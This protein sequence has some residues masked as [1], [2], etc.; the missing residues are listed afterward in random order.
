MNLP[1]DKF[2]MIVV[3]LSILGA[4]VGVATKLP[5][6]LIPLG[7]AAIGMA[8]FF[9]LLRRKRKRVQ[10]FVAAMPEAVELMSRAAP[11]GGRPGLGDE[12]RGRGDDRPDRPGIRPS[13]LRAEPRRAD[14]ALA[15]RDGQ[16]GC[17]RWTSVSSSPPSSSSAPARAVTSPRL[18]EKIG[19]LIR[20]QL[21]KALR[22]RP[23]LTAE[24]RLSGIVLL[25]LPPAL[26]GFLTMSNYN[27]VSPLYTTPVEDEDPRHHGPAPG[28]GRDMHQEDRGDQGADELRRPPSHPDA[29]P[30]RRVRRDHAGG[31]VGP[32]RGSPTGRR[33]SRRGSS[34]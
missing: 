6:I 12:P 27:Y 11:R 34:A 14:R 15:P 19:K 25:A 16:T 21:R 28:A 4:G 13:L 9:W 29:D 26:L 20:Q 24:G 8:P 1:F 10:T 22:P 7:S 5:Y 30:D 33:T 32:R 2:M 31:L 3:A 18:L 17:R 23:R